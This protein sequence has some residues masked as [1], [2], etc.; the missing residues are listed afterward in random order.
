MIHCISLINLDNDFLT[1]KNIDNCETHG[2][3]F[4]WHSPKPLCNGNNYKYICI[5]AHYVY[6]PKNVR[7][8]DYKLLIMESNTIDFTGSKLKSEAS[9]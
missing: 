7:I 8:L 3:P 5:Y 1:K 6:K 9:I 2:I 4:G